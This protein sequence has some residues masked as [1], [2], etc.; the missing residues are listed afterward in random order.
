LAKHGHRT[1]ENLSQWVHASRETQ[2][3]RLQTEQMGRSLLDWL[4]IQNKASD[5]ALK[6]C[7]ELRPTYPIAMSLALSLA[8]ATT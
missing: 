6:L 3:M 7:S 5:A 8:N 2:E 4:R 1:L